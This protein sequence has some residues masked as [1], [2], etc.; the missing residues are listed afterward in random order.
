MPRHQRTRLTFIVVG[1]N[2]EQAVNNC[3]GSVLRQACQHWECIVVDDC[4]SDATYEVARAIA[5]RDP[6]F[7][8]LRMP[9]RSYKAICFSVA[10]KLTQRESIIAELDLDDQLASD[11]VV[12]T[13]L[14]LH[15]RYD[16]IWTQHL[17]VNRSERPWETWRSTP[18]PKNWN[19]RTT[20]DNRVWSK[21][22][23]PG[24]MRT[25][26]RFLFE[27]LEPERWLFDGRPVKVAFDMIYYTSILEIAQPGTKCFYNKEL[28]LYN[29][30]P[31][32]DDFTEVD[33]RSNGA[34]ELNQDMCQS[35]MDRWFKKEPTNGLLNGVAV[36]VSRTPVGDWTRSITLDNGQLFT[37]LFH[38]D[39]ERPHQID[40]TLCSVT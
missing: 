30:W 39:T 33:L 12:E 28:Y 25:F 19:R 17:T 11:D 29:V 24:H 38:I 20:E 26:K 21:S 14:H 13:L 22:F 16:V 8:M 9:N 23:F 27:Q 15:L 32:N 18:L 31:N 4:S 36:Q 37:F 1:R 2:C 40:L 34:A 5:G 3:L 10:L 6:R 35:A 7:T